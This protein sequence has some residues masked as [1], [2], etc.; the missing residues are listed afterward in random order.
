MM[1]IIIIIIIGIYKKITFIKSSEDSFTLSN[2]KLTNKIDI[3]IS[4]NQL[5]NFCK[6]LNI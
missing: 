1:V 4:K 6:N 2:N 3:N 5:K